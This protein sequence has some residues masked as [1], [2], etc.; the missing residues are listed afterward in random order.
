MNKEIHSII[1]D[2]KN[3]TDGEPWYGKPVL[4]LL[5][6]VDTTKANHKPAQT[7]HS[8]TELLYHM[9]TWSEFTLKRMKGHKEP[10]LI[11]FEKMDWRELDPEIHTW[12]KGL[13]EFKIVHKKIIDLLKKK[14]DEF[15]KEKVDHRNYNFRFLLN[16]LIQ[17]NIYHAGQIAYINTLLQ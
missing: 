10:D 17:H 1:R 12:K 6:E 5:E 3:V 16:G 14:T 11:I 9:L 4:A 15:L 2:F 8:A 7:A 13:S